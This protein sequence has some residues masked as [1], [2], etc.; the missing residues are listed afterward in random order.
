MDS[1]SIATSIGLDTFSTDSAGIGGVIKSRIED[2]RVIEVGDV[3]ALDEKGRFTV[4]RVTVSNWETNRF[5]NRLARELKISR[6]R[7][8][9]SGTKDKRAIT[10]QLF[11]VD[12]PQKRV[13]KVTIPDVQI[14]VL[15]R[16][17]QKLKMGGH[18][19]NRF[20]ITIRGCA[21]REGNPLT[22][23]QA[24]GEVERIVSDMRERLGEG[25]FPNWVGP[26]RFGSMRPVTAVVGKHI[27]MGEWQEAVD[28]YV[29]MAGFRESDE[30][31]AFRS[32]WRENRDTE[33]ALELVPKHL[34]FERSIVQSLE[35]KP[36]DYVSAF[37]RLPNNLQLMTIHAIQSLAFNHILKQRIVAGL[38]LGTPIVGDVV[39]PITDDGKIEVSKSTVTTDD[40]MKRISRNCSLGRLA[41][42]AS[43]LGRGDTLCE[44][45]M[46]ELESNVFEELGL[47]EIDWQIEEIPRLS[48]NGTKRAMAGIFSDFEYKSASLV[49][50][51]DSNKRWG[52]GVKEGDR[53]HPEG[54]CINFK[55]TLPPGTY[56]TTLLREF[57]RAPVHQS[58]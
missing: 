8:W 18:A 33:K 50:L 22:D 34:G 54:A 14:E 55:F 53:W 21:D 20:S 1:D 12:A 37:K 16:T 3:P 7:I 15:G 39:A 28:A 52:E 35:K 9:F 45:E 19:S 4:I 5:V 36:D 44:G 17:H 48:S 31:A 42:C 57:T 13:A 43:L 24:L 27:V 38:P 49:D 23:E 32:E 47:A 10:T 41:V 26:Q 29:G 2:F 51:A 25:R 46:A 30:V 6:K 40:T 11:V 56:A 58:M